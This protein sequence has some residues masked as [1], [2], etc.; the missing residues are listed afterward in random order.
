[1]KDKFVFGNKKN[2]AQKGFS[3]IE[4]TI[5]LIIAGISMLAVTKFISTYMQSMKHQRT[6]ENL[7]MAMSAITEYAGLHGYY[8]C[9]ANPKAAPGDT[10][11]GVSKCRAAGDDEDNCTNV[12]IGIKCTTDNSRDGDNNGSNDVVMIGAIPFRTLSD[13]DH[14]KSTPFREH[15][16]TDGYGTLLSY[17]VT[18]H[19]TEKNPENS[20]IRPFDP[21]EGGI[22]VLDGN[23]NSVMDPAAEAQFVIFSHG[24]DGVGGYSSE[25]NLIENCYVPSIPGN[26]PDTAPAPGLY[27]GTGKIETENCDGNDAIFIDDLLSLADNNNYFD[28]FLYY[29]GRGIGSLWKRSLASPNGESYLYNTNLGNIGVGTSTPDSKLHIIGDIST[30]LEM[31]SRQGY[32]D[33]SGVGC[34]KPSFLGGTSGNTCADN[35]IAY[36]VGDNKLE[37]REV[38]WVI[39]NKTCP[40]INGKQSYME[41][42]SNMGNLYC[43]NSLGDCQKFCDGAC[44]ASSVTCSC[45]NGTCSCN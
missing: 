14:V 42:F 18:E 2:K 5:V 15:H 28:D 1:V 30:D 40:I 16:K 44:P 6:I 9:P 22:S 8:P 36:A 27:N 38:D 25:G 11:Y 13:P 10:D 21:L 26:P 45:S 41:G 32:C 29:K 7:E 3:L 34:L 17:A 23:L 20:L 24:K 39:P 12:P 33:P 43:C 31:I 19:L 35:E 37:C 4:T